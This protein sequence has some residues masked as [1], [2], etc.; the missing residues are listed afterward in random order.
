MLR[1]ARRR[2]GYGPQFCAAAAALLLLVSLSVL[3]SRLSSAPSSFPLRL[4]LPSVLPRRAPSDRDPAALFD[5]AD[6]N[7]LN[8]TAAEDDRIDELDVLEEEE[9]MDRGRSAQEEEEGDA[10][11][12]DPDEPAVTRT[13]SSGLFWDHALGVARRR[14]GQLE[15]DP[16]GDR[17]LDSY[18]AR[19]FRTKTAFGSDDQPVDED[20]R[21]KLDSIR[22]IEDALLLKAGS[23]DSPLREGWARWLEGKGNFLRRDRMLRSNLELLNPKNHPL[24]QDPDG[25][26][27]ATLTQG[28]RMVQR[29]L[30]KEMESIPFNVGGGGEAKRADGRRKLEVENTRRQEEIP[31]G[32]RKRTTS[33]E[34]EG[35]VHA[36]GRRWGYFPGI[37]A[38]LTFTDFMEQFLDSRRCKIR[39][40]MVWNSPPWTYGVRHQRGLE[41]LLHHHW[42]ACVVVFSETMELNFFE[43]FVKDGYCILCLKRGALRFRVA[44]A[45]PNLD[46]LLKDTPAHIF[47]SVWFEWRKTLHYPIHYSELL[48]LAALYKYGGI[49]LDSDIIVLNPLHSLKNFVSIEDNTG[50]NSVFNGAVMAFEKNSSLML[51][52]LNEYYSTYDDTLLRWNGADLMTRVIKRISDKA[53]KSSLQLDIKMEPQFAFHPIS[54][55][56]ITRYFAEPADQFERA[57]QDDLLKRMLNESITFHFWNGMTSALVPEPN[58]LMERLL[59]QYCLHCLDVL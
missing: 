33:E 2:S 58:S 25:P 46:E 28:D 41:S 35:R 17:F 38:H 12:Q 36:D 16:R 53:G 39:V 4:G 24:L 54:S 11:E 29:V 50:G 49:Y 30:L 1:H 14:F 56:N 8:E 42:D 3:H 15:Q 44:V 22:R 10:D 20:V 45:M 48:R 23:G 21:L 13:L 5:D 32:Q 18:D 37:D 26:G 6:D 55:I 47:S 52:C 34:E 51:E 7:A 19:H 9:E 43:D 59:N 31:D 27:L 57:E 40:F